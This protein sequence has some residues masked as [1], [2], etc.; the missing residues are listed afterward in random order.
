MLV[1]RYLH[2]IIE[3]LRI[4]FAD[5]S[6]FISDPDDPTVM[7][8]EQL[9][10]PEYLAQRAK[11]FHPERASYVVDHGSPNQY[12]SDT[13]YLSVTDSEGNG[14]SFVNSLS[15]RF[16]SCIIPKGTGVALQNRGSA[17]RLAP[18][19]PNVLASRKRPFNTIIPA[20]VTNTHDGSLKT[21]YGVMGGFMQPQGHVQVLLNMQLFGFDSQVALDAPRICVGAPAPGKALDPSKE[22]DLTVYLE[23]G[24]S[25][26]VAREL[27]VMGHEVKMVSGTARALFGRGQVIDLNY[28][29]VTNQ[30]V[31][32]AG[33]DARGDGAAAPL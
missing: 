18:G 14:C 10:V 27:E 20:I 32:S 3:T 30:R 19:H 28:D 24:I 1:S 21:V 13:V 8:P 33:S 15:E 17:F 4:A 29:P 9:L 11:L 7:Q 12:P 25:E 16:G 23:E 22:I 2:V 26:D 6:W 5:A 31:Y